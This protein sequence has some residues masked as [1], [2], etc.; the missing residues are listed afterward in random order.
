MHFVILQLSSHDAV[1]VFTVLAQDGMQH[2]LQVLGQAF[3]VWSRKYI[4]FG[5]PVVLLMLYDKPLN[6]LRLRT[7][8]GPPTQEGPF[9]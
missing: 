2:R 3:F 7:Q 5:K 1:P 6:H 4:G 9:G 8:E